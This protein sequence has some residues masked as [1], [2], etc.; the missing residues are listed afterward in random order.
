MN[1]K[2]KPNGRGRRSIASRILEDLKVEST[3]EANYLVLYDFKGKISNYFYKNL[4][5]IQET[6]GDGV[7]LQKSVIQCKRLRTA[8]AIEQLAKQYKADVLVFRA[9]PVECEERV[10]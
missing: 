10:S 4:E 7:K 3:E 8:C 6:L 1:G 5:V 9:E 2:R